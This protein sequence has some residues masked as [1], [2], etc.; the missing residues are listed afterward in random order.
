MA[1]QEPMEERN[2]GWRASC[3]EMIRGKVQSL[4]YPTERGDGGGGQTMRSLKSPKVFEPTTWKQ[5]EA[6]SR[7]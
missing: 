1:D 4:V 3:S 2:P 5:E 7:Q 6:S